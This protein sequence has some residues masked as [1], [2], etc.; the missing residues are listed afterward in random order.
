MFPTFDV[1]CVGDVKID[2]CLQVH[3]ANIHF[4]LDKHTNELCVKSGEKI[5]ID[6]C[7]FSLGGNAANV[8]V[9]LSRLGLKTSLYAETGD[10][11]LSQKIVNILTKEGVDKKH[12]I[13][14]QDQEASISIILNYKNERTIFSEHVK[15]AHNF[16]FDNLLTKWI[17][18]TSIGQEWKKVYE[19]VAQF[20]KHSKTHLAFN[21]GTLQIDY[22]YQ[23]IAKVLSLTDILFVN[24][25]EAAKVLSIKYKVLSIKELL[26]QLKKLGPKIAVITDGK[27]GSYTMDEKCELL[28]QDTVP[29]KIVEKT[30]AGDAYAT[31]FLGATLHGLSIKEA[32]M[33]GATN[34]ANVI[35]KVGAEKG[36]LRKEEMH[37][38]LKL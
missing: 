26:T 25:E 29:C 19:K 14:T 16:N 11:E 33:W 10:D 31:G 4:H 13:Q 30:G 1:V 9:G 34:A 5:E 12:V 7:E 32:M 18:L 17:Y 21:P 20:V 37:E 6:K 23:S 28:T 27:N 36:L 15:R 3:D 22:G 38:K 2:E 24:K 35:Q 8:A